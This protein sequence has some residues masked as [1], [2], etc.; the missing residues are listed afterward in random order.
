MARWVVAGALPRGLLLCLALIVV[1]VGCNSAQRAYDKAASKN[2]EEAYRAF[3]RSH[4]QHPLVEE[5]TR[6]LEELVWQA[7]VSAQDP[8]LIEG[9]IA[10]FPNS[11]RVPEA[12]RHLEAQ[13][14]EAARSEATPEALER[15]LAEYPE[16]SERADVLKELNVIWQERASLT[17]E[18]KLKL[19]VT[20]VE[21]VT[22]LRHYKPAKGAEI[23]KVAF[24]GQ[25]L[26]DRR[27]SLCSFESPL[28]EY[29]DY[30]L[31]DS[32]DRGF[33]GIG[34]EWAPAR[35]LCKGFTVS[36]ELSPRGVS[37][38]RIRFDDNEADLSKVD[39]ARPE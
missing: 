34:I 36:F 3:I 33:S 26:S 11:T 38:A 18:D 23:A 39:G 21:R 8:K 29:S 12:K 14:L 17:V 1:S 20:K 24:S 25:L 28:I 27:G 4:G 15:F 19:T 22:E 31:V 9:F 2:T 30:E 6:R 32:T 37:L 35:G 10:E 5:A 16:S 13:A 7:T